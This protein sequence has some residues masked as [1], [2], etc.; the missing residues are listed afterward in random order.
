[1]SGEDVAR[2]QQALER[3]G[4]PVGVHG[5]DGWYGPDTR[6]AVI[7]YQEAAGLPVTGTFNMSEPLP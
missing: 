2:L 4:F 7:R 1:M 6:A 3:G 5:V